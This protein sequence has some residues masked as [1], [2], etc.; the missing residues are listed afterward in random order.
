MRFRRKLPEKAW[1]IAPAILLLT[2]TAVP[3]GALVLAQLDASSAAAPA[4]PAPAPVSPDAATGMTGVR[5]MTPMPD[6]PPVQGNIPSV[7]MLDPSPDGLLLQQAVIAAGRGDWDRALSFS[8]QTA[9]PV[10]RDLIHWRYLLDESSG[11][12]FDE[13][14]AFL[15]AH[16]RWPRHDAL[17]IRAEMTMPGLDPGQ[18][19]AWYGNRVP[20]SG[21]GMVRLGEAL[22][23]AGRRS[24]GVAMI[25][26]AWIEFTYSP[27][28][29]SNILT[30]HGDLLA[31]EM[32]K[33]RLDHLLAHDDIGGAKRQLARVTAADRRLGNARIQIKASPANVKTVLA[34]LPASQQADPEFMF[35]VARA[36]RRHRDDD[37][38]WVVMEKAPTD[39]QSLV[40]PER[41]SVERQI[42]AR[43]ALKSADFDLAYRFAAAPVLD[44]SSGATFMDGEFLAGWIALRYLHNTELAYYHFGRLA[45]GVTYPIS[46]ARAHYWLGR[47]AEAA[48]DTARAAAEYSRAAEQST[49][50]YGQLALA[51]IAANPVLRVSDATTAPTPAA[52]SA[53]DADDRVKAIRLLAEAGDRADMRQFA[54]ALANEPPL[55]DQLGMLAELIAQT[56][57]I[58]MSVRVAKTASYSGYNLLNFLHPVVALPGMSDSPEPALVLAIARQESEF[59]PGVVSGAG[60]RG[61][62]QLMPASAK[63]AADMIG[64]SY[65]LAELTTNP[66][67][68]IQ[69]GMA[70]LNEYLERWDGSYILGIATYNAGPVN[71]RNWVETYGDPRNPGVDPVDWME[72]IPFPETRNYVQRVIENIEV[73]RN[74]LSRTDRALPIIADL[75]RPGTVE[76]DSTKP[77]PISPPPTSEAQVASPAADI[78]PK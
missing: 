17:V 46:V 16:P 22:M 36:L 55:P 18:V 43:D 39:K 65:R 45:N 77:I 62:M 23:A 67:Y 70:T 4:T 41:W 54:N 71:V 73:Y 61:L 69:L 2:L 74:R 15:A 37:D 60:A 72:S 78:T 50:F 40:L 68:N 52:R 56:G 32:Q 49:T 44:S 35:D 12:S 30:V 9:N 75:Y 24:D 33:A 11:A 26:K 57:D 28:D 53:F 51:K 29:E 63:R 31:P 8:A 59:D 76:A 14:N 21:L 13:I 48:G 47:T 25:R 66:A 5:V 3:S 19:I 20:L 64:V 27:S 42:M 1:R 6:P 34:S 7:V 58:A 10:L 38:A